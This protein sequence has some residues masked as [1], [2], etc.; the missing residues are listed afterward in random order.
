MTLPQPENGRSETR[1]GVS[2]EL[3]PEPQIEPED[4]STGSLGER[5]RELAEV[6]ARPAQV[7][8]FK[9]LAREVD[10][11]LSLLDQRVECDAA[12]VRN[13]LGCPSCADETAQVLGLTKGDR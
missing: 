12:L 10:V 1:S 7:A 9:A 13:N 5:L 2:C 4:P 11:L 3:P 8:R 6:G